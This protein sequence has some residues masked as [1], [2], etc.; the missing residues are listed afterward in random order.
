[1][2]SEL[3]QS[4]SLDSKASKALTATT[5][6]DTTLDFAL[7]TALDLSAV[8]SAAQS[9]SGSMPPDQR[10]FKLT[11]IIL[12]LSGGNLCALVFPEKATWQVQ[13][14]ATTQITEIGIEPL[15]NHSRLPVKL[16]EHVIKTQSVVVIDHLR[17]LLP[18]IDE[19]FV[20]NAPKSLLCLPILNQKS[21]AG[22][23]YIQH[24]S[25][26]DVF[27]S[28]HISILNFLCA[29]ASISIEND[30]LYQ[31]SQLALQKAN[32]SQRLL[33][34]VIDTIPQVIF[35][36]DQTST[37]LGCNQNFANLA[38]IQHPE[39]ILGKT[40]DDL[41]WS[42][43][44]A[45]ALRAS[46]QKV[47]ASHQAELHRVEPRRQPMVLCGGWKS[48]KS[49]YVTKMGQYMVFWAAMKILA[50]AKK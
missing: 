9:I 30:R 50:I 5:S 11:Q 2:M 46:D 14:I 18:I 48:I 27:T 24:Q 6:I 37:Y 25:A 29:Q 19:Y 47:M 34:K 32:Y 36:K 28:D 31:R 43:A 42:K 35:W 40:D 10:L 15:A 13:V 26:S 20:H 3:E 23:L 39:E 16:I 49:H 1:M 8:L 38:G 33:R 21:L 4:H 17:Q 41:P 44:E 7:G 12:R 22:V 45:D